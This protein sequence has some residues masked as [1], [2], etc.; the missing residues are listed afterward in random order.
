MA[1]A[2]PELSKLTYNQLQQ[3]TDMSYRKIKSLL[4][5][6]GIEP[7]E[8]DGNSIYFDPKEALPVIFEAQGFRTRPQEIGDD[9][10]LDRPD[11]SEILNPAIQSARL[12]RARTEKTEIEIAK[13]RGELVPVDDVVFFVSNMITSAKSKLRALPDRITPVIMG[14]KD[15]VEAKEFHRKE[16]DRALIDL[17]EYNVEDFID[18]ADPEGDAELGSA[19]ESDDQ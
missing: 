12:S 18:S 11:T 4:A 9:S 19:T 15:S 6:E 13:L 3:L 7:V 14:Y 17:R 16:I 1:K 8:T 5:D 10:P 2:K